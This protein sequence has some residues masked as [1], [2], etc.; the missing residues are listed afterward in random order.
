MLPYQTKP[1]HYGPLLQV[2]S[3]SM[4]LSQSIRRLRQKKSEETSQVPKV[5]DCRPHSSSLPVYR[6]RT[7]AQTDE[8]DCTGFR[9]SAAEMATESSLL[10]SSS[11]IYSHSPFFLR[12][13]ADMQHVKGRNTT[14]KICVPY[15]I[16]FLVAKQSVFQGNLH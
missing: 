13:L 6:C 8:T 10:E 12:N 11:S 1:G 7:K 3:S 9:K 16:P 5:S 4:S 15:R 14:N 2:V